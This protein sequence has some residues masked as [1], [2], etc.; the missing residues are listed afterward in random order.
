MSEV[1]EPN[2]SERLLTVTVDAAALE[3]A[4]GRAARRLSREVKVKGFRPGKAPQR[5]VESMVGAE[6]MRRETIDE[7]L[8]GAVAAAIRE[9]G[10]EPAVSPRVTAVRDA[11]DGLEADVRVTL[12]PEIT[13]LPSYRGRHIVV[14]SPVVGEGDVDAHIERMRLRFAEL[15][16]VDRPGADGDFSLVDVRTRSGESEVAAGSATDLLVEVG[17]E[18]FLEGLGESL[19]GQKAGDIVEFATTLPKGMG[20]EGGQAVDARVLVKQVRQRRLPELTDAWVDEVSEFTTVSEMREALGGELRR[21]RLGAARME[22]EERLLD[23]LREEL[24]LSLPADL[25]VAEADAVLHRFA[26]RLEA[27]KATIEQYM[28]ATGQTAD[29]LVADARTQAILNLR[30]RLLLEAVARAEGLE[31][32]DDDLQAAMDALAAEAGVAPEAYRKAVQEG[33]GD[34]ALAGDILRR[35]AVDRLLELAV[36]VDADGQE[37]EFPA[38]DAGEAASAPEGEAGGPDEPDEPSEPVEVES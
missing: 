36:A 19:R 25:I 37:I 8:P 5:L 24:D 14:D 31:V 1:G 2:P 10:L 21:L 22:L 9:A 4:K 35:R 23:Q 20:A 7:A 13:A 32:G 15:D 18:G 6:T 34:K 17:A 30:T 26:H 11:A 29:M 38:P 27:R 28:A 3:A 33:G 16:D 12:W